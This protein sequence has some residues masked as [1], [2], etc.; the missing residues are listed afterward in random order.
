MVFGRSLNC[1]ADSPAEAGLIKCDVIN[2]H[3]LALERQLVADVQ[4]WRARGNVE[5]AAAASA[6]AVLCGRTRTRPAGGSWR[7]CAARCEKVEQQPLA[8]VRTT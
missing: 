3:H 6:S 8:V 2:Q 1:A 7:P 4:R 5:G